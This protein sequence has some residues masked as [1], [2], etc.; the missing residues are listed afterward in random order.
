MMKLI[1]VFLI[2]LL[3]TTCSRN[4]QKEQILNKEKGMTI[5][6]F[7]QGPDWELI[8]DSVLIDGMYCKH[9]RNK[10]TNQNIMIAPE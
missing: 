6:E 1:A 4:D 10:I 5:E 7:V 9:Y 3:I 8:D 2:S